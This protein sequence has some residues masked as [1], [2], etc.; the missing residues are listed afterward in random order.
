VHQ[1]AQSVEAKHVTDELHAQRTAFSFSRVSK[2]RADVIVTVF[3]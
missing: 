1:L 2:V 3:K